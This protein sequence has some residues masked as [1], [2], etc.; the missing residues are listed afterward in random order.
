DM[1]LR[2][3]KGL[4]RLAV[5]RVF[6]LKGHGTV[7]TGTVHDGVLRLDDEA[8]DLRLMPAGHKVRVRSIHAQ[9]QAAQ[10]AR[11]GQ[12]CAL[13]LAGLWCARRVTLEE[14]DAARLGTLLLA[15]AKEGSWSSLERL[16][17]I[18]RDRPPLAVEDADGMR[19]RAFA[20]LTMAA[21]GGHVRAMAR[22]GASFV[23][24]GQL[25]R[26]P[27]K[28]ELW[29]DRARKAGSAEAGCELA[30]LLLGENGD[31]VRITR[32]LNESAGRGCP[33]ASALLGREVYAH[34][35]GRRA[36]TAGLERML[37]ACREGGADAC[38]EFGRTM[39]LARSE[40]NTD[41][42]GDGTRLLEA[43]R[44]NGS[45]KALVWLAQLGLQGLTGRELSFEE[46]LA[47]LEEAK[48][49]GCPEACGALAELF[50]AGAGE[51]SQDGGPRNLEPALAHA[52]DG[53]RMGDPR[54][55]AL[56]VLDREDAWG[57]GPSAGNP[58]TH[59]EADVIVPHL[60]AAGEPLIYVQTSLAMIGSAGD[61]DA[62]AEDP[63][64]AG[65][66]IARC[67]MSALLER[68]TAVLRLVAAGAERLAPGDAADA[69]ARSFA[70]ELHVE[71]VADREGLVSFTAWAGRN[72]REAAELL[73]RT[74]QIESASGAGQ[75]AGGRKKAAGRAKRRGRRKK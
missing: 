35:G 49:G 45:R 61:A 47:M 11:A 23:K 74:M 38:A 55:M 16:L 36:A 39:C 30:E 27:E 68:D 58:M 70:S 57:R 26:S 46:A 21:S 34:A 54:S 4:F 15:A 52:A 1:A 25:G 44:E 63:G 60:T 64:Y 59:E 37:K 2:D 18:L 48:R 42:R 69:A 66:L 19:D 32:L 24:D 41:L 8:A 33:R 17:D 50:L 20:L 22:L 9:N 12:R 67:F 51:A 29:L 73:M 28:A 53:W 3:T 10:A 72:A 5:D 6:T 13:A 31:P 65:F 71:G 7:V 62:E 43:A 56:L 14:Q 40:E 75:A